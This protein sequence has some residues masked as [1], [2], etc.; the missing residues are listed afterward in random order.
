[1]KNGNLSLKNKTKI[2]HYHLHFTDENFEKE[3][4][5]NSVMVISDKKSGFVSRTV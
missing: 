1:M 4:L 2:K 5:S 3:R